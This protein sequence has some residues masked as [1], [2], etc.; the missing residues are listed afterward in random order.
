M[1]ITD[2]ESNWDADR[3]TSDANAADNDNIKTFAVGVTRGINERELAGISSAPHKK[4]ENYWTSASF[5]SLG[6]IAST[7]QQAVCSAVPPSSP[8]SS[9]TTEAATTPSSSGSGSNFNICY[10]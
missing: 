4:N 1:V 3:T 8:S 7:I 9:G 5:T 6:A 10:L 2:G